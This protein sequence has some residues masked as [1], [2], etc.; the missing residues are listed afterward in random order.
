VR[1]LIIDDDAELRDAL[2]VLLTDAG[3]DVGEASDG[4]DALDLIHAGEK[5]DLILLDVQMPIM[6]GWHFLSAR[7]LDPQLVATPIILMS[8]I[9]ANQERA[10]GVV[11]EY[12]P[13]PVLPG[14]LL[15]AIDRCRQMIVHID[16]DIADLHAAASKARRVLIV[17]DDGET[18]DALAEVLQAEGYAVRSAHDGHDAMEILREQLDRRALPSVIVCDLRMPVMDGWSFWS[19][20]RQ[21]PV[22]ASIPVIVMSGHTYELNK[23]QHGITALPKPIQVPRLLSAI[24]AA[25]AS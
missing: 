1:I 16:E 21:D 13:K 15:A 9:G 6:D 2:S 11:S 19:A 20:L 22:L 25:T 8:A 12:L 5:P 7:L 23:L 14:T 4:K 24:V 10:A 3:F 17:D 18:C